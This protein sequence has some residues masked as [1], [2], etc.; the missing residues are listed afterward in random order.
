MQH[1]FRIE[2][3]RSVEPHFL[4]FFDLNLFLIDGDTIRLDGEVLIV[5][6]GVGLVPVVN[7]GS[8]SA[9][10]EPLAE[11]AAL[12]QRGFGGASSARQPG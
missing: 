2:I 10:A 3:D 9:S 1:D 6:R 7:G 8:G 12:R 11:I 4:P 5:V